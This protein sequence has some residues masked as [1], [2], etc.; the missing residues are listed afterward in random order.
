MYKYFV[1]K[2]G[3]YK[4][5]LTKEAC[6]NHVP[7]DLLVALKICTLIQRDCHTERLIQR[8]CKKIVFKKIGK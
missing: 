6:L 4:K 1:L 3:Q 2:E 8:T 5:Y 7:I